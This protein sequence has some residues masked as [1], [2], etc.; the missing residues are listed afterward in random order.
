MTGRPTNY[1]WL[2]L[3][4][5]VHPTEDA[6]KVTKAL[7]FVAGSDVEVADEVLETHHGLQQHV[8]EAMLPR[9]RSL[10]DALDRILALEDA[11]RLLAEQDRRTDDDGVFYVR[12]DKQAAFLGELALTDGEDCVQVRL[13]VECHPSTREAAMEALRPVLERRRS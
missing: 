5:V 1:H 9:G 4:T 12:V 3:R 7:R 10:R 2:R 8:L 11:P 6:D 13:K